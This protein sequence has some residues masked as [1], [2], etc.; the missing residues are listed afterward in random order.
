MSFFYIDSVSSE[1][2]S[3]STVQLFKTNCES[4]TVICNTFLAV[5]AQTE[6]SILSHCE[7]LCFKGCLLSS[8]SPSQ[9]HICNHHCH[10]C[11]AIAVTNC[12]HH[13]ECEISLHHFNSLPISALEDGYVR[14]IHSVEE[15]SQP[16]DLSKV[17]CNQHILG[18][19]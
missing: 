12:N 11:I 15:K 13:S 5:R 14:P 18:K 7:K 8:L 6:R 9:S 17:F 2:Q 16:S 3:L 10:H 1:H 19:W 4:G